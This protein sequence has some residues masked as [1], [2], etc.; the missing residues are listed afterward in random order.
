MRQLLKK[1]LSGE[2][3]SQVAV[4]S[5]ADLCLL[6]FQAAG[7][8]LVFLRDAGIEEAERGAAVRTEG[9]LAAFVVEEF[10]L[11]LGPSQRAG[12]KEGPWDDG[13]SAGAAAVRAMAVGREARRG[14]DG[15]A[16][17]AAEAS[18][19]NHGEDESMAW[20]STQ[21]GRWVW[22]VEN[23]HPAATPMA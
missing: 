21:E 18:S 14:I 17:C 19:F 1:S 11:T 22:R 7:G 13:R 4:E 3:F 8:D 10:R 12:G 9:A 15:V 6:A 16:G 5:F 20:W 23:M 2:W